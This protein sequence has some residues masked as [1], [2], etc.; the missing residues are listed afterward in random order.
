LYSKKVAACAK[1]FVGDGGTTKGINEG[2]T[3]ATRHEL[4]TIHMPAY[5]NSITKGVLT[6]MVSYSSWNGEKMHANRDL[7]T[8]FL[9]NTLRFRVILYLISLGFHSFERLYQEFIFLC[10]I[11]VKDVTINY[12]MTM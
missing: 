11:C 12:T 2:N 6:V 8:G 9:K 1:H 4:F 3:V 5:Y 7:V 10:I